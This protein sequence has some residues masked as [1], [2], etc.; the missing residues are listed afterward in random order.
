M[1][2]ED[3]HTP[4][5]RTSMSMLG[6]ISVPDRTQRL[7]FSIALMTLTIWGLTERFDWKPVLALALQIE[8][9]LTGLVGWCP[10]Y[11]TYRAVT[12]NS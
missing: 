10:I 8:M 9:L 5:S 4:S 3:S 1:G 11:C 6:R 7:I 2:E 12:K